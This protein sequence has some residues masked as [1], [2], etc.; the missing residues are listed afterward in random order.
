[1]TTLAK[2]PKRVEQQNGFPYSRLQRISVEQYHRMIASG[3]LTEND[4][5]E[6]LE[7]WLVSK[8]PR[9]PQHDVCITKLQNRLIRMLPEEW[10]VRVQCAVT[11]KDSEPEP[12]LAI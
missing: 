7:G 10:I 3:A 11:T 12:D 4:P 8:M 2:P 6:L 5:I 1:M 9:D